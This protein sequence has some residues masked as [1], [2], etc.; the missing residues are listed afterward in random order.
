LNVK[1]IGGGVGG[2]EEGGLGDVVNI[3]YKSKIRSDRGGARGIDSDGGSD[4]IYTCLFG[5]GGSIGRISS[6]KKNTVVIP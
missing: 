2:E 6:S 4:A 1:S 5:V 3:C